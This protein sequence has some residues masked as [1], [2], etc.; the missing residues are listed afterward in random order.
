MNTTPTNLHHLTMP[1]KKPPKVKDPPVERMTRTTR[2]SAHDS[3]SDRSSQAERSSQAKASLFGS[4]DPD[5]F[6]D[7]RKNPAKAEQRKQSSKKAAEKRKK[8]S[9]QQSAPIPGG[10]PHDTPPGN[11]TLESTEDGRDDT[12]SPVPQRIP[13]LDFGS[14]DPRYEGPYAVVQPTQ[15][16][17]EAHEPAARDQ[18]RLA[19]I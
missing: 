12:A 6:V 17:R 8:K 18:L 7:G 3:G 4:L 2:A 9:V 10:F 11:E 14:V 5:I 13:H 19:A 16:R 1:P 15:I